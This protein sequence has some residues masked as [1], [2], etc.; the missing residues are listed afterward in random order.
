VE[1]GLDEGVEFG[2]N[3]GAAVGLGEASLAEVEGA[4]FVWE[5]AA[6]EGPWNCFRRP[7]IGV[8]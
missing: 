3:E 2:L 1:F 8:K 7:G 6:W 4:S 5:V